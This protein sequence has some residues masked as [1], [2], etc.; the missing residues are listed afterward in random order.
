M[1]NEIW[2]PIKGYEGFYEVSNLGAVR[3]LD[4]IDG[5]GALRKGR[6]LKLGTDTSGYRFAGLSVDSVLK[7]PKVHRLVAESFIGDRPTPDHKIDHV[8]GDKENNQVLNLE[9]VTNR[10][11]IGRGRLCDKNPD[12]SS[13]YRGVYYYKKFNKFGAKI[14]HQREIFRLGYFTSEEKAHQA[15]QQKLKEI[16]A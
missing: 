16:T 11:N 2:K 13:Q 7:T 1:Q 4:R 8:D 14:Q 12:K 6:T 10:E 3:S 15:Y 5:R 9:Y